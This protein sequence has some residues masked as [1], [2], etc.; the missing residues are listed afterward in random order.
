VTFTEIKLVFFMFRFNLAVVF[1]YIV[2]YFFRL[3]LSFVVYLT[4]DF[5]IIIVNPVL[6][7]VI[8]W[9]GLYSPGLLW[10][11]ISI[12]FLWKHKFI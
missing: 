4:Y 5:F 7:K 9:S 11:L 2:F 10:Y 3:T 12:K 6:V 1:K 8:T